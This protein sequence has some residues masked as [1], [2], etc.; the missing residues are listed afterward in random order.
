MSE[1]KT[2]VNNLQ[3]T[4][5]RFCCGMSEFGNFNYVGG[6][7]MSHFHRPKDSSGWDRQHDTNDPTT[8]EDI[9]SAL[10][11]ANTGVICTTGEGQAYLE[12][13]L[14]EYGFKH[15]FSYI[16]PGHYRTEIKVWC[17][18]KNEVP[19]ASDSKAVSEGV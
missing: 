2:H 17:Y 18:A 19:I 7:E 16:N 15:V 14:R 9:K 12:P 8:L 10:K 3:L 1:K 6:K 13:T 5:T 11:Y 4:G